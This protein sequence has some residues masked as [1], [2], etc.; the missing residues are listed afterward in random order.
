MLYLSAAGF[1]GGSLIVALAKNFNV[2]LGGRTVQVCI[3]VGA[4]LHV[5]C[6]N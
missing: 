3:Q 1:G 5:K 6:K 2:V 4:V